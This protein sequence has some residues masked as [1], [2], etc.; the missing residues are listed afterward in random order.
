MKPGRP[1]LVWC[2]SVRGAEELSIQ[3]LSGPVIPSVWMGTMHVVCSNHHQT[4]LTSENHSAVDT[5]T[6]VRRSETKSQECSAQLTSKF[7]ARAESL[8]WAKA[9][10]VLRAHF[11]FQPEELGLSLH[12]CLTEVSLSRIKMGQNWWFTTTFAFCMWWSVSFKCLVFVSQHGHIFTSFLNLRFLAGSHG[13]W[14]C[15][16]LLL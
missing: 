9:A 12:I 16:C 11:C 7:A 6:E 13:D 10:W 14:S 8:F 15:H 2:R 1:V 5:G 3:N 4:W